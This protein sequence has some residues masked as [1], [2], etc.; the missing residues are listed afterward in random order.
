MNNPDELRPLRDPFETVGL[1]SQA[2]LEDLHRKYRD[3][4]EGKVADFLPELAQANPNWF[5]IC[6]VTVDGKVYEVGDSDRLFSIQSISK[7][8]VYGQALEDWGQEY[9]LTKVGVEPTGEAYNSIL[10]HEEIAERDYN[11]MVNAGAIATTSLI[12]GKTLGDRKARLLEMFGQY[13]GRPVDIDPRVYTSKNHNNNLNR[14]MAYL[15]LTFG[16]IEGDI[17]E[18]LDLYCYQCSLSVHCKDLAVMAATL[19][20]GGENPIAGERAIAPESVKNLLSV[21]YTCGMY[22]FSGQ[23]A[24]QVGLPAKSGLA[25]AILAVVPNKMGI[26]VFS[27]PLNERNKSVRGVKVCEELSYQLNLHIFQGI[28]RESPSELKGTADAKEMPSDRLVSE[29]MRSGSPSPAESEAT[30]KEVQAMERLQEVRSPFQEFLKALHEKYLPLRD[31]RIYVSEPGL[32]DIERDWFGI[33]AVTVDGDIYAVGDFERPFLIQSISKVFVYGM[34]LEDRG[35]DYVLSKVDVEP[36]GDAY[37]SI[38]KVEERSKRPYNPMVNA[39]AIATSSL[40]HGGGPAQRL[41][42]VLQ[43]YK[44][45]VGHEVFVDTPTLVSEQTC[46]DR[47]WATAYLLRHFGMLEGDLRQTL[48]LYLEHCS[49]IV[50]ARDLAM[51]GATLANTGINPLTG[52]RAIKAHYVRDLLSVMCTCGMYD[53]AGE[54]MYKVGIPAKSGVG[55]G[56][57]AVVPGQMGI[58]VFSPPLDKRGNSVRGIKVFQELSERFGLHIFDPLTSIDMLRKWTRK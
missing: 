12:K 30:L 26:A 38:L 3:L 24:Y 50:N 22:D 57:I 6:V 9:V 49:A 35:R 25:G 8:F 33:C 23:W 27:P 52:T 7:P 41:I 2:L 55:G 53:F 17:E 29:Y 28:S 16:T 47:S 51:M 14:A 48:D 39:G 34:A 56:I 4:D 1:P 32:V 40:I 36:T 45:Y 13:V 10:E 58:A 11:P 43:M 18:V 21:M 31:G 54:W 37:D 15:M 19:A 46:G 5:G 42:R 20:N 44:K